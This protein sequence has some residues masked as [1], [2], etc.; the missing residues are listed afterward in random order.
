V[1]TKPLPRER[2]RRLAA[3]MRSGWSLLQRRS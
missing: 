2:H 1:L 3:L